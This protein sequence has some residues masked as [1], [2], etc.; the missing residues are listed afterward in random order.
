[1]GNQEETGAH[2]VL[3]IHLVINEDVNFLFIL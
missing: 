2:F 3:S 1:M